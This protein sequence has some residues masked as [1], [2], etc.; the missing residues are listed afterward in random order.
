ME[1][2]G[3]EPLTSWMPFKRSPSWAIPPYSIPWHFLPRFT[4]NYLVFTI[5][6]QTFSWISKFQ[7]CLFFWL[8]LGWLT[9]L[10]ALPAEL[11]PHIDSLFIQC[12]CPA[13]KTYIN[14]FSSVCQHPISIFFL[15]FSGAPSLS[16]SIRYILK[17][18]IRQNW[19]IL[20]ILLNEIS[21]FSD[22][23]SKFRLEFSVS[24]W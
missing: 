20:P 9:R 18:E 22:S 6:F 5:D 17:R 16:S 4:R 10:C 15:K 11:Y 8:S 24:L 23:I 21:G 13:D 3:I 1:I 14:R 19:E 2:S 12:H 7:I